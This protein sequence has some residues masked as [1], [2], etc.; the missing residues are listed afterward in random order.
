LYMN[1]QSLLDQYFEV[2]FSAPEGVKRLRELI[3]NLAMRGL[4]VP[5]DPTAQPARELLREIE[6]EK[7]R[8]IRA[9]K[10]KNSSK[11]P[12]ILAEEIPYKLPETWEWTR[13]ENLIDLVSGQHLN[14][15]EYNIQS[16]GIPYYTGPSDFGVKHPI[17]ARWTSLGKAIAI[18][19]D[20]LLTVKGAGIGK[21]NILNDDQ[22][23]IGRQIM[24]LRAIHIER[25]FLVYFLQ[26]SLEDLKKLSTGIAIP[27][28][29]RN[30]IL[31]KKFPLPPL[32][33]Q[34]RIVEK[35]DRLMEQ[36]DRLEQLHKEREQKRIIVHAAASHQ[37]LNAKGDR[38]LQ[39]AWEFLRD[40]FGDLYAVK[41]NI[42]E[43]RKAILQLAVMGKLVPQDPNDPPASEL[44][45]E[46]QSEKQRLAELG[47]ILSIKKV[48]KINYEN[49]P[50]DIPISWQWTR[51]ESICE[52]I[53]DCPHSTP[54]FLPQGFLCIDT[55]SFKSNIFL[56]EKF[57][58]VSN[59]TFVERVK[60]LVPQE[61]DIVFAREGSIGESVIIPPH[62]QCCLGQRVML[63]RP[64]RNI[65]SKYLQLY[66]SNPS[67]LSRLL[68]IYKGI[69]AK[70][71]NV[72]DMRNSIISLPPLPEQH[73]IVAKVDQ[74]MELCD[75]LESK[76]DQQTQ[77][78]TRLLNTLTA[79]LN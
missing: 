66:I 3:L 51:V 35:V 11:L 17:T 42:S 67:F 15:N 68:E 36:C 40:R 65:S 1:T 13:L 19:N 30:D 74:L 62:M 16:I 27:G 52:V 72:G 44:L 55:N 37:L 46:I 39:T 26:Y 10:I 8:L 9:G 22:A 78:Q 49:S 47:K 5:Q 6:A 64:M 38:K 75:R 63:F 34:R 73:R 50:Y 12:E 60:R 21:I 25:S 4:L 29:S 28:I 41:E 57:R 70:H 20:V 23:A 2:A 33:E 32:E 14:P 54:R 45:K 58:Y 31:G 48:P 7:E 59:E 76:I 71:V 24:A 56:K 77:T 43:L 18:K 79:E 69:G 53:V 61:N